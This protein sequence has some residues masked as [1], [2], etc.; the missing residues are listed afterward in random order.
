MKEL[1]KY[2]DLGEKQT[3]LSGIFLDFKPPFKKISLFVKL[4]LL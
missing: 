2:R 1:K 4:S 3:I